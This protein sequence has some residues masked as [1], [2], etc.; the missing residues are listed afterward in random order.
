MRKHR[1]APGL[2]AWVP[3]EYA[4][5]FALCGHVFT[6]PLGLAAG[7]DKYGLLVDAAQQYGFG[8][9]EVGSVTYH[10][11]AG[12]SGTRMFRVDDW[13]IQNRMGLNNPG[14]QAVRERLLHA[15]S[16]HFGVSITKSNK[17]EIVGEKGIADILATVE[18]LNDLG[19]YHV[20]NLSCPNSHD[21]VTFED[22]AVLRELLPSV[23]DRLVRPWGVKLSPHRSKAEMDQ[24]L[25]VC[26][27]EGCWFYIL[28]N[29]LPAKFKGTTG[30][31]SGRELLPLALPRV[32]WLK[33]ATGKP[34]IA[35]GGVFLGEHAYLY[36]QAGADAVQAFNGFVRGPASGPRFAHTV[37]DQWQALRAP[38]FAR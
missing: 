14:A 31:R 38:A 20:I 35:C 36:A 34:V 33:Q 2:K 19:A 28:G 11:H 29:T 4:T 9:V 24:T 5:G 21:G 16:P 32:R 17:P 23:R 12:N 18:V 26:E 10:A 7:F 1:F 37:L 6:N 8:W 27:S 3:D 13:N 30:G 15:K 22:P 25:A